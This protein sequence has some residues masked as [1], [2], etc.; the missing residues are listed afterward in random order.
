M[1]ANP[2]ASGRCP[3]FPGE[4]IPAASPRRGGSATSLGALAALLAVAFALGAAPPP[5]DRAAPGEHVAR[6]PTAA[7]AA[8]RVASVGLTVS[9]LDRAVAF[10]EEVLD[11]EKASEA[12][13]S[14]DSFERLTGVFGARARGAAMRLG[15]EEVEL[16]QFLAPAGRAYPE[17]SRSN[18]RWFQHVAIVTSDME[19]AYA[20]LRK[21]GVRHASA[22]PQRLPDWNPKAGGIEAFYFHDPDGHVLEV[23]AFPPGRGD[24]RWRRMADAE[25]S[26]LFLG[27]DHTAIVVRDTEASLRFYRDLLG[28]E[29]AGESENWGV[30]Q[31]RLNNVFGARLRITAL[32]CRGDGAG[33]GVELLEYLAPQ[34]GRPYPPDARACDLVHWQTTIMVPDAEASFAALLANRAALV[35]PY[36]VEVEADGG[37]APSHG[38]TVRDPD[39]H[40]VRVVR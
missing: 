30:E 2:S 35:S 4:A 1:C 7:A 23:I 11:F 12:E 20:R 27:I 10:F 26:R 15:A 22:G 18:D 5:D 36:V 31:E 33:P 32:R 9:D 24:P 13:R 21:H 16:T 17:G 3:S 8:E 34:D 28:M 14:G 25:P 6:A 29:V 40:A 39:G 19:R 38:A 37:A